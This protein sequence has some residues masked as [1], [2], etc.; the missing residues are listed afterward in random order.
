MPCRRCTPTWDRAWVRNRHVIEILNQSAPVVKV[1]AI[2]SGRCSRHAASKDYA[3]LPPGCFLVVGLQ[4]RLKCNLFGDVGISWGLVNG[5]VGVIVEVLYD[6]GITPGPGTLPR[7]VLVR[8]AGYKGPA[9][10]EGDEK[11][12]PVPA[13]ERHGECTCRCRRRMVPLV[14]SESTTI[15]ATEGISV[16]AGQA[17]RRIGIDLGEAKFESSSRGAAYVAQSRPQTEDDFAY[18]SPVDLERFTCIGKG[19]EAAELRVE[20]QR[21]EARAGQTREKYKQL[22]LNGSYESLL[23]WAEKKAFENGVTITCFRWPIVA[24][25]S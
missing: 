8:F 20:L 6:Q 12:V 21:L 15:H 17:V 7:L 22:L 23:Q 14:P 24:T 18:T 19:K 10:R 13:V 1:L 16:G 3:S 5:A 11:L 4:V 25:L 2:N 9:W